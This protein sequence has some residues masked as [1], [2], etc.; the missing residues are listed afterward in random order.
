[1]IRA[2][3]K[4]KTNAR[5]KDK[6]KARAKELIKARGKHVTR[7]MSILLVLFPTI[8]IRGNAMKCFPKERSWPLVMLM[9]I[10]WRS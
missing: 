8:M 7:I 10:P 6:T 9:S 2:R 5:A 3:E 4:E 1:M